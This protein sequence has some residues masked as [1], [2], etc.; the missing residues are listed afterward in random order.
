[1]VVRTVGVTLGS[2]LT[3]WGVW[4]IFSGSFGPGSVVLVVGGALITFVCWRFKWTAAFIGRIWQSVAG[5]IALIVVALLVI[6]GL[7]L[8]LAV[9]VKMA[10]AAKNEPSPDATV[11]VLGAGL[12]GDRPS[13][14]LRG[15]LDAAAK[16]LEAHPQSKCIVSG[17]QG[18]D[19]VCTEASVMYDY[20]VGKGIDPDRI[21]KEEE[22]TSTL[23]NMRYSRNMI[24]D[25]GLCESVAI[26]TQEFHQ[27]RAQQFAVS[28]G[29]VDVGAIT[30][31]TPF[32]LLASYWIRDFAGI[33]RMWLLGN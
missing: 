23:E 20:L 31:R 17:G 15:R 21:Y 3:L 7:V 6:A 2:L 29:L 27:Y 28:V 24:A 1:M 33:C 4:P 22:A 9:S 14:I 12:R 32:D 25:N 8:F 5:K 30:A 11:V 26:V 13:K 16:Y 19:E 10:N 18:K